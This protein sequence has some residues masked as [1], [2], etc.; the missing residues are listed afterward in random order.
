[1]SQTSEKERC[2]NNYNYLFRK[3]LLQNKVAF[4][5]G[6]G[7]GIGF[8]IAEVLMRHGCDVVIASRRLEKVKE[9]AA[10]LSA[11]TGRR[12]LPLQMDVR[13]PKKI[14]AAVSE[15]MKQFEKINI[16]VNNAAGNFLS[17]AE[18][19]SFN[20]FRTVMDI[21]ALGTYNVTKVIFDEY[22]KKHG[23]VIVNITA[24]LQVR[25]QVFQLHAGAAKAAIEAMTRHLAVEWGEKGIRIMCVA[26]GPIEQTEGFSRLGGKAMTREYVEN[27]PIQRVGTREDI[28]N[29]VLYVVS[30]AAKLLTGTT[31]IADGGSWLTSE[32]NLQ[33]IK[34]IMTNQS[35]L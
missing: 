24:T 25:G 19:L 12:C 32:N 2:I 5:T 4:I 7:T 17:P 28:A 21:D 33:R 10:T 34:K 29:T 31:I 20:A 30:D 23:G 3:D 27:I 1:M 35:K 18:G 15:A 14:Q 9:S 8:T 6:G 13:D 26:P 11:E 16:L 22:M